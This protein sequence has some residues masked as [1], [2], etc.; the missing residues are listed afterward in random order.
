[1]LSSLVVIL[2]SVLDREVRVSFKT[3]KTCI[4][5]SDE[6]LSTP[7]TL[8]K[9]NWVQIFKCTSDYQ[10]T[11]ILRK[12]WLE[13]SDKIKMKLKLLKQTEWNNNQIRMNN[14]IHKK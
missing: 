4:V 12:Y 8:K 9:I 6:I 3:G 13:K 1:M 10:L 7:V 5:F 11:L 14:Y 2:I